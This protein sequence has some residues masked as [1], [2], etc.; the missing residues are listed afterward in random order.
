MRTLSG[1]RSVINDIVVRPKIRAGDVAA[2][3]RAALERNSEV[4]ATKIAVTVSGTKVTLSG[5]VDAWTEREAAER[6]AW[7]VPGVTQVE[8][9]IELG[10]P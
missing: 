7:S 3:I 4:E 10:R 2:E 8:D 6:A 9:R 1:V 5:K